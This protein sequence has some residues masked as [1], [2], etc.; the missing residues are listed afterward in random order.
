[1]GE[2]RE[3]DGGSMTTN[4]RSQ[5]AAGGFLSNSVT[6]IIHAD[7]VDLL[8]SMTLAHACTLITIVFRSKQTALIALLIHS[9]ILSN[10]D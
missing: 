8:M 7:V 3:R 5:Y 6:N 9:L 4:T 2:K 10:N 1:M